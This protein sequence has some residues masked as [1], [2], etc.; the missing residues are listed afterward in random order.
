[1]KRP[2]V[3]LEVRWDK[4]QNFRFVLQLSDHLDLTVLRCPQ[5]ESLVCEFPG[6][7]VRLAE[8]LCAPE[9]FETLHDRSPYMACRFRGFEIRGPFFSREMLRR[10]P[11]GPKLQK[12]SFRGH[13]HPWR[14]AELA[15]WLD[16]C[17]WVPR[18][19]VS[20]AWDA[21]YFA[22]L[23]RT[24]FAICPTGQWPWLYR[25][26]EAVAAFAIPASTPQ[27][28]ARGPA[29]GYREIVLQPGI[30]PDYDPAIASENY[31]IMCRQMAVEW[32]PFIE[33]L[34]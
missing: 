15:P 27:Q 7:A 20:K 5:A 17:R 28:A 3:E 1:M 22:E 26:A 34:G 24:E 8:R 4:I 13:P 30:V 12:L 9:A 16:H 6:C 29:T 25:S 14:A 21:A 32:R 31:D 19:G 11:R 2:A 18:A 33:S 10:I 23:A